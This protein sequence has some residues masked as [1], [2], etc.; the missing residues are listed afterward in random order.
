MKKR[1]LK[2]DLKRKII[3]SLMIAPSLSMMLISAAYCVSV[4]GFKIINDDIIPVLM[5]VLTVISLT[6]STVL[7]FV[8][9]RKLPLVFLS[10]LFSLCLICYIAF[11]KNGMTNIYEDS[12]IETVM[13]IFTV[14]ALSYMPIATLFLSTEAI[15]VFFITAYFVLINTTALAALVMLDKKQ[16]NLMKNE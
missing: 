6:A 7:L 12:V 1:F 13:L 8:H 5:S 3:T 4:G 15:P 9:K 2:L 10:V 11:L 16:R 14:P